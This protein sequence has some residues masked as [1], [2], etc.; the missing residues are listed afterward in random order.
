M[1]E[2]EICLEKNDLIGYVT[3]ILSKSKFKRGNPIMQRSAAVFVREC[4]S[5][6]WIAVFIGCSILLFFLNGNAF[7]ESA[8]VEIFSPQGEIR[9]VR[10]VTAR[11]SEEIVHFG[12][13]RLAEP[14]DIQ[15]P[16]PGKGRWA[17][18]RNW[19]YD[20]HSD[21]KAGLKCVFTLKKNLK[22][23]NGKEIAGDR[24]FSFTTGGPQI[25][26]S[27]PRE[28][29]EYISEDQA[30]ILKLDGDY[31][32]Q[33]VLQY[34]S[35]FL[36]A[37]KE[38]AGVRILKGEEREEVLKGVFRRYNPPS[39][40]Q[41]N[42]IVIFKGEAPDIYKDY[43]IVQCKRTLPSNSAMQLIWGKGI[44]SKSGVVTNSDQILDFK[45]REPFKAT[46]NCSRERKNAGCIPLLPVTLNFSAPLSK[47]FAE[48]MVARSGSMVYKPTFEKDESEFVNSVTFEGTFPEKTVLIVKIPPDLKDDAGRKLYNA[49]SF[50]LSV[51]ME[52]YPPL[53]KFSSRFGIIE[54]ADP[55]LPVTVRNIEPLLRGKLLDVN[56]K[57]S[58]SGEKFDESVSGKM[59]FANT[60][61][62]VIQ[63]LHKL[64]GARR[65]RAL[66][67][68]DS[69]AKP[70]SLPKPL[71]KKTFEVMGIPLKKTGFHIVELESRILGAALLGKK[72]NMY[73]AAGALVTNLS[74]HFKWGRESSLVFVT[75]LDRGEPVPGASVVVRDVYG[76]V[77]WQ[78]KTDK[79]GI[80]S[81]NMS[82]P[83]DMP[84]RRLRDYGSEEDDHDYEE[85]ETLTRMG[86]GFFVFARTSDDMTF[87]HSSWDQGIEPYRF[88]L[89]SYAYGDPVV[90]H[91]IFDRTLFRA[92]DTVHMKH[93]LRKKTMNGIALA[94]EKLPDHVR[95]NHLGSDQKYEFPLQWD[96]AG[97]VAETVWT[98]PK[99]AKLG[100]YSVILYNDKK[101]YFSGTF[102]VEEF[103]IPLMR[104]R[105]KPLEASP[106]SVSEID[107]DLFVE[108][109]SGG[110]AQDLPVKLRSQLGPR[111]VTFDDYEHFVISN[112]SVKEG[113]TKRG[114]PEYG[115]FEEEDEEIGGSDE[116]ASQAGKLATQDLVL[117]KGGALRTKISGISKSEA[118]QD[119]LAELEY[120][121]PNGE[122]LTVSRR[123]TVWPSEI[124][125]GIETDDFSST[126]DKLRFKMI[127]FDLSGK[128]KQGV[129]LKAQ[130]FSKR[131]YSHRKRL[132]GGFYAYEHVTEIK[133]LTP[134]ACEGSTSKEGLV[135][136]E[137][138][139]PSSG[140]VI[141]Q[142][143]GT[144]VSGR[145]ASA[146]TEVWVAGDEDWWGDM[147][148]SDRIDL[149]PEK[150]K[151]EPGEI[152]LFQVRMPFKEAT[153]LVGIEREGVID[154]FV[155][156]I[157]AKDPF[158]RVPVKL[159]YAPNV[160][161]SALCV[162]G[163][164]GDIK[165]TALVD[166]GRPSYKLGIVN[167]SVGR[168]AH[169]IKVE[170]T[171]D[172]PVYKVR[173][174]AV[175][176]IKAQ[177]AS[178]KALPK[179]AEVAFA[180]V[181]DGL[182]EL[183]ANKS[184]NILDH[185]M[186]KR[187][188]SI[189][190][191]TAQSQV[192][193]KRHYGL[194]ALP[195]GGGGGKQITRELF[196]TLLI[197]KG[198]V[199]L[200]EHGE[201]SVDVPLNDSL[202]S[203]TAAAIVT[204]GEDLFGT[205]KARI[206][207]TQDLMILS[208]LPEMVRNGD[209]FK[210]LF[211]VRNVTKGPMKTKITAKVNDGKETKEL[212]MIAENLQAGESKEIGWEI[213]VPVSAERLSWEVTAKSEGTEG[214]DA[215]KII[216]KVQPAVPVRVFQATIAQLEKPLNVSIDQPKDALSGRGGIRVSMKP[217]L[218]DDV[219]G[220]VDYMS[221]YPYICMEQ[222][223]S[224][225]VA[226]QNSSMWAQIMSTLPS[227]LD[228]EG[229]LKYFPVMNEGSDI[230][231]SYVLAIA[232][233]TGWSIPKSSL[234]KMTEGLKL[235][236]EGKLLRGEPLPNPSLTER[237]L[238]AI[239]ALSR[240]NEAT[241]SHVNVI[242]VAPNL[243][244]TSA[245]I[246]WVNILSRVKKIPDSEKRV[247][248]AEQIIRSR[249]N[250]QGTHMGFSTEKTDY[251]WWLMVNGDVNSIRAVLTFMK[252]PLWKEDMPRLVRGMVE[253]QQRGRW[254]T[255]VAN[256]WGRVAL[257]KFSDT[258]ESADV[259]GTSLATLRKEMQSVDW[260]KSPAGRTVLLS[261]PDGSDKLNV[262]HEGGGKPWVTIQSL[263]A[264]PLK[265]PF[266]S[267][268][269]IKK[270]Y[271]PIEQKK[272]NVWSV[273]DVVRVRLNLEAQSDMT[274]VVVNDPV[275]AGSM[276]LGS[277]LGRDSQILTGGEKKEG[278]I[279]PA[280]EERSFEAFRVYYRY[281]PKGK[282]SIEYTIRLNTA[283]SF[284][285]PE[286]RV[287]AL[288]TPEMFG[289]TPNGIFEIR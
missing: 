112:G 146:N 39:L 68:N 12:D 224:K 124:L 179:G 15:C 167:I 14:F 232:H 10:Q 184:W 37:T 170:V 9:E 273:G 277:G 161:I 45:T 132:I 113:I 271:T 286:T 69:K 62:E 131:Y 98:I 8:S 22:S 206:Q 60:D 257:K 44:S 119:V 143:Q 227:Y 251:L 243:W 282:W 152:A 259:T 270:S 51:K 196:D 142:A 164:I 66:L 141:V 73:V 150:R 56:K 274:W 115:D 38:R 190:T 118:P 208:G 171:S 91:T 288:Y 212:P 229:L 17:D 133:K 40:I 83:G 183:M 43:V 226:L 192:I 85:F 163:R 203:F 41:G 96:K 16:A 78:G 162:R 156:K 254:F 281:V 242:R 1:P 255:T 239:E 97:G 173:E 256:A 268:Y 105:I 218:A 233:E 191:S 103:K 136:C 155:T 189:R 210:A 165:P 211:T 108:Y 137:I 253:R 231:T 125:V 214:Y 198:K 109:L 172:K 50:P 121:D 245:V 263:A 207:T 129:H 21:L 65:E 94:E 215:A 246:D 181:D 194:K 36:S 80:A 106:V 107:V 199:V 46:L 177:P 130:I 59:Q 33:S 228:K 55:V 58:G 166:L 88:K 20:F 174:K 264:I 23:L 144:D 153:V 221:R 120:R 53:A 57:V 52:N 47:K 283:G 4:S 258:F 279:W 70:F 289:E 280:F 269:Q 138:V 71:S 261:W 238:A 160:Y 222:K 159:S 54:K 123:I 205:G 186:Q 35:C 81:V 90:A 61:E 102:R 6:L 220:I 147:G 234:A 64:A 252:E 31:Q 111:S 278:W 84:Y 145:V 284:L 237:K 148:N 114:E 18:G 29:S 72:A 99:E 188:Y 265:M 272:K 75:T 42:K 193:G 244:P 230:L 276:I 13:P 116:E 204:A 140:N 158:I 213:A 209:R 182:L 110:S 285:L 26:L 11:F 249:L 95:V 135:I 149:I 250:F 49:K 260:T 2:E 169:E 19:V 236:V 27:Y 287:E 77:I 151:Y 86:T 275:P 168:K 176:K 240:Y 24:S 100:D 127:A 67:T 32:E 76:R 28:G 82:L 217:K 63:W 134:V 126:K 101:Q 157:S 241:P 5:I 128:P 3:N 267:G 175:F 139:S 185:M 180:V 92:A 248:E 34:V 195:R 235:F 89:D 266:S 202:T 219:S 200:D 225:A 25:V 79:N 216:Q 201:A 178:G 122:I 30:F 74:A 247:L 93:V 262:I 104:G 87:V 7:A 154:S 48:K 187:G 117:G 223:I 197:W